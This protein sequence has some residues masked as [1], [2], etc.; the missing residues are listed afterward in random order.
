MSS[1]MQAIRDDE[2]DWWAFCERTGALREWRLYGPQY[3]CARQLHAQHGWTGERLRLA[4]KHTLE[5]NDLAARQGAE[6]SDLE[7]YL[8]LQSKYA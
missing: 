8:E 6:W 7:R 2:S 3:V 4:V 1:S 5:R